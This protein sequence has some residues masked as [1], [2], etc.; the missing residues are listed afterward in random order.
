MTLPPPP[1]H[2]EAEPRTGG[3]TIVAALFAGTAL[4][5]LILLWRVF[6]GG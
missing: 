3:R 4:V 2:G 1:D 6:G 5:A